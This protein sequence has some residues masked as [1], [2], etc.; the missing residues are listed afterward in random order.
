M[1]LGGIT[2]ADGRRQRSKP[3][4]GVALPTLV[5][6]CA[7]ATLTA[8]AGGPHPARGALLFDEVTFG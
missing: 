8:A 3:L 5:E 1:V 6:F 7:A 4:A 2:H